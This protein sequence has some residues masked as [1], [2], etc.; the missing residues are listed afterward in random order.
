MLNYY[1]NIVE[2]HRYFAGFILINFSYAIGRPS[3]LKQISKST[4]IEK[5]QDYSATINL[6]ECL[7]FLLGTV[8]GISSLVAF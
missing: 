7:G 6:I 2:M 3:I 1:E 4:G 5:F 8:W